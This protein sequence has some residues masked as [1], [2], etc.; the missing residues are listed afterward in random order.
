M[1]LARRP[2]LS[3]LPALVTRPICLA[4]GPDASRG[5]DI[6]EYD[7]LWRALQKNTWPSDHTIAVVGPA[8]DEFVRA[9]EASCASAVG[10]SVLTIRTSSKVRWQSVRVSLR[11]GTADD[12]CAVHS[13]LK[14]LTGTKAIV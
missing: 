4:A 7:G 10:C 12:F 8:G 6:T 5:Y 1:L 9:V 14:G 3:L 13:V 2:G 11:C